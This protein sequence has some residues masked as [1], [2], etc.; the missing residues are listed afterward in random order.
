MAHLR[1]LERKCLSGGRKKVLA[2]EGGRACGKRAIVEL[3]NNRN[4][5]RGLF[6]KR[7]G[8]IWLRALKAAEERDRA[9]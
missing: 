4:E 7:C 3:F 8:D 6:C 9:R 2:G 5:G 1:S